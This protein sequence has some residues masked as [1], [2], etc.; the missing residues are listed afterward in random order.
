MLS[1]FFQNCLLGCCIWSPSASISF[2]IPVNFMPFYQSC[3]CPSTFSCLFYFQHL[4]LSCFDHK[5][6]VSVN[7]WPSYVF[8]KWHYV[9]KR[10]LLWLPT[11]PSDHMSLTLW[12]RAFRSLI[13]PHLV[14]YAAFCG[15]QSFITML[16]TVYHLS[17]SEPDESSS[18]PAIIFTCVLSVIGLPESSNWTHSS[19]FST[20]TV[21]AFLFSPC[22]P[23]AWPFCLLWFA[24]RNSTWRTVAIVK[25]LI[26]QF[27]SI[28]LLRAYQCTVMV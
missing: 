11:T 25:L 16:T 2:T 12:S 15:T 19:G 23:H 14:K 1:C 7:F 4:F 5:H 27:S 10:I 17:L 3:Q 22:V 26:T 28:L 6:L 13:I 20:K 8:S 24:H 18:H 9:Q 21:H